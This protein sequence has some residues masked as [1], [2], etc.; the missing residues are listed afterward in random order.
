MPS[1]FRGAGVGTY[2]HVHDARALGFSAHAAH[3]PVNP[4][5][6]MEHITRATT[7]SPYISLTRSYGVAVEYARNFGRKYP[8]ASQ[9]AYVYQIVLDSSVTV[10]D[11]IKEVSASLPDPLS[12]PHYA[13]DGRP[14]FLLGVIDPLRLNKFLT[15]DV[16]FPP[17]SGGTKRPP[18]LSQ[19]LETFVRAL[20]DAELLAIDQIPRKFIIKRYDVI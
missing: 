4:S 20:R 17:G 9:P 6:I 19:Q 15:Q 11:P 8:S 1:L 14:S 7:I 13:H 18:T 12:D 3:I 10:I 5:T 2:W 16:L